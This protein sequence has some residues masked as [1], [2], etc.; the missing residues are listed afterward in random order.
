[1]HCNQLLSFPPFAV[2]AMEEL[3]VLT[4]ASARLAVMDVGA[5]VENGGVV[6]DL[7]IARLQ[8]PGQVELRV[9]RQ[10]RHSPLPRQ[11]SSSG[12]DKGLA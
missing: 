3:Q 9:F 8:H 4:Q 2:V 5:R 11:R 6:D 1:M 12:F 10:R 7:Q